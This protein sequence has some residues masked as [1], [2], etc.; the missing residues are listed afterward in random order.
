MDPQPLC[1]GALH[2]CLI[3]D[4]IA[5]IVRRSTACLMRASSN[6]VCFCSDFGF[7]RRS[8]AQNEGTREQITVAAMLF[9]SRQPSILEG[10]A[11]LR[12]CSFAI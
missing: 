1:P 3:D 7:I 11:R 10:L 8:G 4:M 12:G 2:T 5:G 9:T 6:F